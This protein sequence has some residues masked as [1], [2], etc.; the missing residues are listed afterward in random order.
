MSP[1]IRP[2]SLGE[3]VLTRLRDDIVHGELELGELLSERVLA[4]KLGVSK[5][6]VR[7]SLVRLEMEGLVRIVPQRGAFVFTMSSDEVAKFSEFRLMLEASALRFAADREPEELAADLADIVERMTR[8]RNRK[9][10]RGYLDADTAFHEAIFAHCQNSYLRNAYALHVGKIAA[11]RTHLASKPLHTEKSYAEHK[12]IAQLLAEG[13]LQEALAVLDI[14]VERYRL[15]YASGV[16]DIA[17]ADRATSTEPER[18]TREPGR[19]RVAQDV[20]SK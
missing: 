4:E 2:R 18:R 19:R 1:I 6:P 7:E 14:H 11:L 10:L 13:A 17:A 8:A 5:T 12:E 9:D 3:T 16:D 15:T 20:D